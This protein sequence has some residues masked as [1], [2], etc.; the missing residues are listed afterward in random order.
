MLRAATD[1]E[2]LIPK[3]NH[4][5]ETE[6]ATVLAWDKRMKKEKLWLKSTDLKWVE[7][8]SINLRS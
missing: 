2:I 3:T 7:L 1:S 5:L 4:L 6:S 8:L